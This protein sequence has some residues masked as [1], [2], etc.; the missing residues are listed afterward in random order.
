MI[1]FNIGWFLLLLG[2]VRSQEC[3]QEIINKT[4]IHVVPTVGF[5]LN[6][7]SSDDCMD[8]CILHEKCLAFTFEV[9]VKLFHSF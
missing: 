7:D 3:F 2:T 4:F 8:A 6:T 1:L 5:S 9:K